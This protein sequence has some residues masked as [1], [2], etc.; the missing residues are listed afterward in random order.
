MHSAEIAMTENSLG[1]LPKEF[2]R[3]LSCRATGAAVV[4]TL[5]DGA[6]AGFFALSVTHLTPDPPT[7]M[8]SVSSTTSALSGLRSSGVLAVNYLKQDQRPLAELFTGKLGVKGAD[9]FTSGEWTVLATGSP[10]L[11]EGLGVLDC[12]VTEMIER[13]GAIIV[14]ATILAFA[15]SQIGDPLI[16]FRG[17]YLSLNG[18]D[19]LSERPAEEGGFSDR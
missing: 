10:V 11:R 17:Q 13:H 12:R 5:E 9:R 1:I 3:A 8:I 4:T 15:H 14:L 19:K 16:H 6:P 18:I 2:W 7:L